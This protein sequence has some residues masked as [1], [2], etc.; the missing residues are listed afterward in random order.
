MDDLGVGSEAVPALS[1]GTIMGGWSEAYRTSDD[2]FDTLTRRLIEARA[3][4]EVPL[5]LNVVYQVPGEFIGPDFEGVRT[6]SYFRRRAV[7]V[8]QDA[9]PS[10][11]PSDPNGFLRETLLAA[12]DAVAPWASRRKVLVD[13][14]ALRAVALKA[15]APNDIAER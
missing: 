11:V 7:L 8:V 2:A 4:V 9:V 15:T 13:L 12:I 10:G 1:I 14:D 6:G 3:G 5:N